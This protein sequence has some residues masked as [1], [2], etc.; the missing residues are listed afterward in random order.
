MSGTE[1]TARDLDSGE[2]ETKVIRD[3]W[4]VITDGA[5]EIAGVQVYGNGTVQVTLKRG[6]LSGGEPQ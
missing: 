3:D 2:T 5:Y 4:L 6:R 1:I